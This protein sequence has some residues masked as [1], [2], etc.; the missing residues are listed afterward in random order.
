MSQSRFVLKQIPAQGS[1]A[2]DL[3]RYVARSKLGHEREGPAARPLFTAHADDLSV[4][5]AR[6]WLSIVGDKWDKSDALHYVLSFA[7]AREYELLG[8]DEKERREAV[9]DFL[10]HSLKESLAQLG[11][12]EMRWVAGVHRNTDNPHLHLLLN[13]YAL[14]E[15]TGELVRLARL[16]VPLVAHHTRLP[17]GEKFFGYGAIIT[18]FAA[19]IDTRHRERTRW[20]SYEAPLRAAPVT[21]ALLAPEILSARPPRAAERLVGEWLRAEVAASQTHRQSQAAAPARA[22]SATSPAAEISVS[23]TRDVVALRAA[24]ARLDQL[25]A[26]AGQPP[27][28]AYLSAAELR[29]QLVNSAAGALV[30]PLRQAPSLER[31]QTVEHELPLPS[32]SRANGPLTPPELPPTKDPPIRQPLR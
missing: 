28:P 29:E 8:D 27:V 5:E 2:S 15:E 20:L 1:G 14:R 25:S 4:T 12:T 11:V 17:D 6:H 18:E 32:S 10:R 24:V 26:R 19:Q 16:P 7:S 3:T 23:G 13:R 22:L 9:R 21:R 31:Q 30:T